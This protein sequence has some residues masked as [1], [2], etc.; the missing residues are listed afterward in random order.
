MKASKIF[1]S[2]LLLLAMCLSMASVTALAEGNVAAVKTS[3]GETVEKESLSAAIN[4]AQDGDT[5][6]LLQGPVTVDAGLVIDKNITLNLNGNTLI[7]TASGKEGAAILVSGAD[8]TVRGGTIKAVSEGDAGYSV[9]V[10]ATNGA[11]V[12]LDGLTL[13]YACS[14]GTMLAASGGSIT[15]SGGI[16]SQDPSAFLDE[17]YVATEV[18][19]VYEVAEEATEESQSD[20]ETDSTKT[21][22]I[23]DPPKEPS[24][25]GGETKTPGTVTNPDGSA[26]GLLTYFKQSKGLGGDKSYKVKPQPTKVL[27]DGKELSFTYTAVDSA[28]PEEGGTL[29]IGDSANKAVLDALAAGAYTVEVQFKDADSAKLNLNVYLNASFDTTTHVKGSGKDINVTITDTPDKVIVSDSNNFSSTKTL[30]AGTDYTVSGGTLTLTSAA[31]D[32]LGS[33]EKAVTKYVGFTADYNGTAMAAPYE[34]KI[35][36]PPS[37]SP[38]SD[39]WKRNGE[40][41]FTVKPDV[42]GVTIDGTAVDSKN[43]TVSG[44]TLKFPKGAAIASLS[45]GEHTLT[46]ETSSGPVSAKITIDPSLGYSANTGNQH[47]KGSSKSMIFIASDPVKTVKVNGTELSDENYTISDDKK[48]VTLKPAYLNTLKAGSTYT[49]TCTLATGD[50]DV[51]VATTFTILSGKSG[52]SGGSGGKTPQTGDPAPTLWVALL[53]V[54]GCGAA[55][56][57]PRLRRE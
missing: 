16:Y 39:T 46:V 4:D 34:I 31:L 47:T 14:G 27:V 28:K 11:N 57:L 33:D 49:I 24:A 8:V 51:D 53:L 38:T 50:K 36:P 2:L 52:G 6:V 21:E 45:Y 19:G 40:K 54:S 20:K 22:T 30:T 35:L 1:L 43:Y 9:G 15:V 12:T 29:V 32:A 44:N 10:Q 26:A 42:K 56:L 3:G 25:P 23:T 13:R 41:S 55:A 37:I 48:I 17:G 5:V 18:D 7:F